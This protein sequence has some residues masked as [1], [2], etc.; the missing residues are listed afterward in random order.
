LPARRRSAPRVP[1]PQRLRRRLRRLGEA[2]LRSGPCG[3]V[4]ERS[5]CG[6]PL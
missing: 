6:P 2:Q 3:V 5:D 1:P 4:V